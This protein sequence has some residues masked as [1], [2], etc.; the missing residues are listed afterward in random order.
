MQS[1]E[2]AA[3]I[4]QLLAAQPEPVSLGD[5]AGA[6]GLAKGTTH[7]ILQ[8]LREVGFVEQHRATGRYQLGPALLRLGGSS[9]DA[10]ELRARSLN[11]ADALAGRTGEAVHIGRLLDGDVLVVH[12]VF[13]PDDSP[14][15]LDTGALLP[16]H[17]TALGKVLLAFSPGA[18]SDRGPL[19]RFTPRTLV[20]RREFLRQLAA[21][22]GSRYACEFEE[23]VPGRAGVAAPIRGRGN[24]LV[25]SIGVTGSVDRLC[26]AHGVPRPRLVSNVLDVAAE[27]SRDLGTGRR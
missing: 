26:D 5:V 16:P 4:L 14:Q 13:R 18:A 17:A 20:D 11:W 9:L 12:H 22:R 10:N 27:I 8:T 2:R 19:E 23:M 15:T 25:G 21:V 24:L 1:I 3:A 7:G 6:L